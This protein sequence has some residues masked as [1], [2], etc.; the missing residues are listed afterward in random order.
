LPRNRHRTV[1]GDVSQHRDPILTLFDGDQIYLDHVGRGS[2]YAYLAGERH[3]LFR[4]ADF[5]ELYSARWGRPSVPVLRLN[6]GHR[7]VPTIVLP[8]GNVLVEPSRSE[9]EQALAESVPAA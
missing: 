9:L 8:N 1:H 4:D 5:A 6:G 7:A 2:F 3:N